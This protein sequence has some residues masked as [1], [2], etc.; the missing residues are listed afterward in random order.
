MIKNDQYDMPVAFATNALYILAK[1]GMMESNSQVVADK[2]I[3]LM[4]E[5]K[6]YLHGEGV[7]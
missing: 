3:P 1:N 5:K 2:L 4:H 7:A 6:D